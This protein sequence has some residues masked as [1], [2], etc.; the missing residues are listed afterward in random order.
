MNFRGIDFRSVAAA[1]FE[2]EGIPPGAQ[3]AASPVGAQRTR[4]ARAF[5][6]R[7]STWC[8]WS[9]RTAASPVSAT[10]GMPSTLRMGLRLRG[11]DQ[12]RVK[13]VA[14]VHQNRSDS[15]C[16]HRTP[17]RERAR[18]RT[19]ASRPTRMSP[20]ISRQSLK[21]ASCPRAVLSLHA[22]C[23]PPFFS[24]AY[25]VHASLSVGA[26]ALAASC[27]LGR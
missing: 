4:R 10:S 23:G 19:A 14:H 16:R 11:S 1:A 26:N 20:T 21:I 9:G 7:W 25:S 27:P 18:W 8:C 15:E 22:G 13:L 12:G 6:M 17:Q 3:R 2:A 24:D 5:R